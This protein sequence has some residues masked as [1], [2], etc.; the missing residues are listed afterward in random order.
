MSAL[1]CLQTSSPTGNKPFDGRYCEYFNLLQKEKFFEA[2]EALESLWLETKGPERNFYQ[3]LIQLAAL[4]VHFQRNN[5]TGAQELF[6]SASRY[7]ADYPGEHQGVSIGAVL[8]AFSK[9]LNAWSTQSAS[10]A[11]KHLPP[12]ILKRD[13]NK[14]SSE[15]PFEGEG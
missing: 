14:K 2:H 13:S 8:N 12:I 9:F 5:L 11:E 6:K 15:T 4:L 1:D 7:L 10:L 3:G